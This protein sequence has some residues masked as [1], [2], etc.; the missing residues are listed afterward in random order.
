MPI[1]C[2]SIHHHNFMCPTCLYTSVNDSLC[3]WEALGTDCCLGD[4]TC[5]EGHGVCVRMR[6]HIAQG[7]CIDGIFLG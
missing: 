4:M 6:A 7:G 1:T 3:F 5:K 2:V